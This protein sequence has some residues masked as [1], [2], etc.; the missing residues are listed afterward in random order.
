MLRGSPPPSRTEDAHPHPPLLSQGSTVARHV[1][2]LATYACFAKPHAP[3]KRGELSSSTTLGNLRLAFGDRGG[4]IGGMMFVDL[5]F[6]AVLT[7]FDLFHPDAQAVHL[8]DQVVDR[9]SDR[10]GQVAVFE[11]RHVLART[12]A[13]YDLA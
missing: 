12:F 5:V 8:F 10:V 9:A 6:D 1:M 7:L 4:T 13:L 2:W 3:A 11:F